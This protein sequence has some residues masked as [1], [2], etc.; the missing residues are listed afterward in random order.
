MKKFMM[1]FALGLLFASCGGA[2]SACDCANVGTDADLAEECAE[3]AAG[4][5]G[6][7]AKAWAKEVGEC[8]MK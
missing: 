4:L 2:P 7:D 1:L 3:Y 6:E 5:E 8:L